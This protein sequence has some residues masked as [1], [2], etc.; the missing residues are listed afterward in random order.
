MPTMIGE[1]VHKLSRG[2]IQRAGPF[3]KVDLGKVKNM[4]ANRSNELRLYALEDMAD[5][6]KRVSM[7]ATN[8]D[9]VISGEQSYKLDFGS[10]NI[11]G[12]SDQYYDVTAR[13]AQIESD[14]IANNGG[15]ATSVAAN[16][17]A[18]AAEQVDRQAQDVVLGNL[19][20]A[21]TN[22]R[23][24]SVQAVQDALDIQEQKQADDD[25]AQSQAL[26]QEI[27]DRQAAISGEATSRATDVASLQ[28]QI[29]TLIG[30]STPAQLQNL[31]AIV[32]AFQSADTNHTAQLASLVSR[33]DTTEA[34]LEQ[35]TNVSL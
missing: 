7:Q 20:S 30:A 10:V 14:A 18:I 5:D 25:T 33:M 9:F 26:A 6:Q 27:S 12:A 28:N 19:I 8:T 29:T 16:Q 13:F 24:T 2:G 35:L 31:A 4:S 21:E 17:V 32:A 1:A 3:K 34:I 11:K 22:A 15:L 23:A